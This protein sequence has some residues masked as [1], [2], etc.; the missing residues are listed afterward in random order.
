MQIYKIAKLAL[1]NVLST[2]LVCVAT[3]FSCL[4]VTH[5]VMQIACF[6]NTSLKGRVPKR[7][8]QM[9]ETCSTAYIL[10]TREKVLKVKEAFKRNYA[11]V[12]E[13]KNI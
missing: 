6:G 10:F 7:V 11:L 1:E 12:S 3:K 8:W 9:G 4:I 5:D 13:N 2:P